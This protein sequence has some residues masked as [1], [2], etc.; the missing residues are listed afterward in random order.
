M[1]QALKK[2]NTYAELQEEK[3]KLQEEIRFSKHQLLQ[4]LDGTRSSAQ[5]VL[6]KGV[7]LPAGVAGLA[8]AGVKVAQSLR[9][10]HQDEYNNSE[11]YSSYNAAEPASI[12]EAL[13]QKLAASSKWY[14]RLLPIAFQLVRNYIRYRTKQDHSYPHQDMEDA[15]LY[16]TESAPLLPAGSR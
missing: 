13:Q 7:V 9:H 4:S 5:N 6:M 10:D 2:I 14:V 8:V 11:V 1:D 16:P 3:K 12:V 15:R